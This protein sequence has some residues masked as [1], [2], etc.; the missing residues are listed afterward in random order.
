MNGEKLW[1]PNLLIFRWKST[2]MF[3]RGAQLTRA[4]A[5]C[6]WVQTVA[7]TARSAL[8]RGLK[9]RTFFLIPTWRHGLQYDTR[10]QESL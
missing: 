8:P 9:I 2:D 6:S 7:G 5:F 3:G 10:G 1:A 4:M